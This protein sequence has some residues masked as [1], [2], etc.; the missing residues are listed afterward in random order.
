MFVYF[1]IRYIDKWKIDLFF[2]VII[3]CVIN[4]LLYSK[5]Y[6]IGFYKKIGFYMWKDKLEKKFNNVF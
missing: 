2:K 1:G 5:L 4:L 3:N 6:L